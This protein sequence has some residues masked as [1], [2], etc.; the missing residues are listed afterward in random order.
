MTAATLK[1]RLEDV[2]EQEYK[3]LVTG[4]IDAIE[5]LGAEKLSV[6]ENFSQNYRSQ[7]LLLEPLRER[8]VR[9]QILAASAI[10][11]M[12]NAINKAREIKDVSTNL[13]TYGPDGSG[14][15]VALQEDRL[16]SK[17]S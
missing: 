6:L 8:L 2:L 1:A 16:L 14:S 17:R 3:A 12:R 13:R 5:Q 10:E 7:V 9:N 4:Q 11:G 15:S